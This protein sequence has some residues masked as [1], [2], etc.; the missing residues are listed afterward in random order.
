M[1]TVLY[2][3]IYLILVLNSVQANLTSDENHKHKKALIFGITGQDGNYLAELLLNKNYEVYGVAR[4]P[5]SDKSPI[6][7]FN[8]NHFY[9]HIGDIT[10][11]SNLIHLIET[12]RPDEIYNLA[13]QTHVQASFEYPE[14]TARINALGTL[15]ILEAIRIL[16]LEKK[17]RFFQ[18]TSSELYGLAQEMPQIEK[19]PFYPRSPYGVA[20]LYGY[21]ITVNYRESYGIFACN[22]ILFNHESPLRSETF[23]TRKITLAACRHKLGLQDVLYLGNLDAKRDW[24]YAKD[25]VEAMWLMLQQ[26]TP[27]DY[28]ISTG[29][30]HSVREFVELAFKELDID[31]KWQ[32]EGVEE[33]GFDGKTGQVIVKID[34]KY[35]RPTEAAFLLGKAEKAEKILK[36]KSKTSFKELV[37]IMMDADYQKVC[38]EKAM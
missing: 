2:Y 28:I 29:E 11:H 14:E 16:G 7:Q 4:H 37:K 21:W 19:T 27:D 26:D 30:I 22:G 10:D 6:K 32:G 17:V 31:I 24:G 20:K 9:F 36:W 23:V 35:Y 25:Y 13:A 1:N 33:Q 8:T 12:I 15:R 38:D 5:L 18:A 3:F 34:P